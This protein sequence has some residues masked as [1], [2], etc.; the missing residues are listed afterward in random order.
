MAMGVPSVLIVPMARD[1]GWSIGELSAPQGLRLALFGLAAPLAAEVML[2]RS[3]AAPTAVDGTFVTNSVTGVA[4]RVIL[5]FDDSPPTEW[6][7]ACGWRFG[8]STWRAAPVQ[9]P[10]GELPRVPQL[11]CARCIPD[12]RQSALEALAHLHG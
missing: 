5:G 8:I 7:A 12:V 6:L 10:F 2:A 1:L 11:L 4:H 9:L 3:V